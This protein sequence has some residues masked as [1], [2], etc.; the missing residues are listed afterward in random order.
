MGEDGC[1]LEPGVGAIGHAQEQLRA[2]MVN[3]AGVT[4]VFGGLGQHIDMPTGRSNPVDGQ[5]VSAQV[6]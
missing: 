4:G 5:I 1:I 3:R 2:D 6:C